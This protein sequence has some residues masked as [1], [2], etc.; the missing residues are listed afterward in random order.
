MQEIIYISSYAHHLLDNNDFV[1]LLRAQTR[2]LN[3]SGT[4]STIVLGPDS[5]RRIF[6]P[7][8]AGLCP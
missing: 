2:L 8:N 4:F 5:R 3:F 1:A 7:P 6:L